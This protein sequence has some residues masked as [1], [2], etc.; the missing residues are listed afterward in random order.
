MRKQ[1]FKNLLKDIFPARKGPEIH[2]A[3]GPRFLGAKG[4]FGS[5]DPLD[6]PHFFD[7]RSAES[8]SHLHF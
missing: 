4:Y 2:G 5:Q 7:I 6:Y 1:T 3:S 8:A